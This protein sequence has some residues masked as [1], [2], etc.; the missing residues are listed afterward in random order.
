MQEWKHYQVVASP[1]DADIVLEISG[2]A[3]SDP[4]VGPYNVDVYQPALLL[5]IIDPKTNAV[6]WTMTS[7]IQTGGLQK[8]RNKRFDQAMLVLVNQLRQFN[9]EKLTQAEQNSIQASNGHLY[10]NKAFI[11]ILVIGI[12]ASAALLVYSLNHR[13]KVPSLQ[14]CPNPPFCPVT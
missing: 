7:N 12:A 9:G 4:N 6:L 8:T 3:P 1:S 5:R 10:N 14:S 2:R 13:P 11:A